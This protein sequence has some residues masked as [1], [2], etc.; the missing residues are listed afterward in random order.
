MIFKLCLILKEAVL[1]ST[2]I[3]NLNILVKKQLD[4]IVKDFGP[5]RKRPSFYPQS[6]LLTFCGLWERHLN[7]LVPKFCYKEQENLGLMFLYFHGVNFLSLITHISTS[8]LKEECQKK[9]PQ[10]YKSTGK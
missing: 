5:G 10:I 2:E 1:S 7:S 4:L 3:S 9:T 6:F 8:V